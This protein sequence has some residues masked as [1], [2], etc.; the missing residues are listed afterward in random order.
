MQTVGIWLLCKWKG[1]GFYANRRDLVSMRTE[2]IWFLCKRK[3]FGF[4]ANGRDLVSTV[5]DVY[6]CIHLQLCFSVFTIADRPC[7]NL[8]WPGELALYRPVVRAALADAFLAYASAVKHNRQRAGHKVNSQH[9]PI[10]CNDKPVPPSDPSP[11]CQREQL[12][13]HAPSVCNNAPLLLCSPCPNR[14]EKLSSHTLSTSPDYGSMQGLLAQ[15]QQLQKHEPCLCGSGGSDCAR[16]Q[17]HNSP[18]VASSGCG[19]E[20]AVCD[21]YSSKVSGWRSAINCVCSVMRM[22]RAITTGLDQQTKPAHS[23]L[24]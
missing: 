8:K 9:A 13:L 22:D 24:L 10:G 20:L 2:G 5:R 15:E 11:H 18:R 7:L 6:P 16:W 19:G 4:Y 12:S 14:F 23:V 1:F 3:G 17:L 21:N